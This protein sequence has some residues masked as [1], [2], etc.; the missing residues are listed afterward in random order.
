MD[1]Q[2][3][4]ISDW[5][6]RPDSLDE[7]EGRDLIKEYLKTEPNYF[8]LKKLIFWLPLCAVKWLLIGI[9]YSRKTGELNEL[10]M[11]KKIDLYKQTAILAVKYV[12]ILET[13]LNE[14]TNARQVSEIEM[15]K[16]TE[17]DKIQK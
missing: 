1:D 3:K 12:K 2:I 10:T 15:I 11:N 5:L 6:M 14:L 7:R 8:D 13:N 9:S 4:Q 17:H 16:E